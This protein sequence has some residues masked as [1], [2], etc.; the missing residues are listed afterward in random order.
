MRLFVRISRSRRLVLAAIVSCACC[1]FISPAPAGQPPVTECDLL[2]AHP[3]DFQR[4]K[5][6]TGVFEDTRI[7]FTL[8]LAACQAA[9][10][11]YPDA[12][13]FKYQLARAMMAD[14]LANR[15]TDCRSALA[16]L[17]AAVDQG[18][19]E[20]AVRL[21]R[22]HA[23]GF[24]IPKDLQKRIDFTRRGYDLGSPTAKAHLAIAIAQ[25]AYNYEKDVPLGVSIL[26][27]LAEAGNTAALFRMYREYRYGE[28][29]EKDPRQ[30][31]RY[32]LAAAERGHRMAEHAVGLFFS[33][34]IN[35]AKYDPERGREFLNR[36][37]QRGPVSATRKSGPIFAKPPAKLG[38]LL[39]GGKQ[40]N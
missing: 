36:A 11:R 9:A 31:F 29:V 39:P 20:A 13:R 38:G 6:V 30:S 25:G 17:E 16:L 33:K 21:S 8:A 24:R 40:L 2:A 18:H 22:C 34:G 4:A 14:T 28:W 15:H 1:A 12:P 5:G 32:L 35:G 27:E 7:D 19:A 3:D 37:D 26:I 10:A 23:I